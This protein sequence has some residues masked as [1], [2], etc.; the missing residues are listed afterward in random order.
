[1]PLL[2]YYIVYVPHKGVFRNVK[3]EVFRN[4]K[5]E[6]FR[7]VKRTDPVRAG[8]LCVNRIENKRRSLKNQGLTF[9]K[10]LLYMHAEY[11]KI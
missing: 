9:W 11:A 3:P 5:P 2:L 7:N 1:M 6:V 4:V 8:R 10:P